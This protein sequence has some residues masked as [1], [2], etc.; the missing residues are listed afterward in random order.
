MIQPLWHINLL[1]GIHIYETVKGHRCPLI[2]ETFGLSPIENLK[3]IVVKEKTTKGYT[4]KLLCSSRIG[5]N[6][7][8]IKST[9]LHIYKDGKFCDCIVLSLDFIFEVEHFAKFIVSEDKI[10][11]DRYEINTLLYDEDSGDIIG[12]KERP[13]TTSLSQ[14]I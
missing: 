11:I 10:I 14:C 7:T 1:K 6:D 3:S 4:Y 9:T 5:D 8:P 13:D 2:G 12:D